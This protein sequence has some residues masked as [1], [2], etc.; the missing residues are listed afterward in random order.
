[1]QQLPKYDPQNSESFSSALSYV[2]V[3]PR[4]RGKFDIVKANALGVLKWQRGKLTKGESVTVSTQAN[5][6][7]ITRTVNPED[8]IGPSEIPSV[9]VLFCFFLANTKSYC[10]VSNDF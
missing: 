9:S 1:M 8:C 2:I 10:E 7:T 3:G 4:T 5:G 6:E